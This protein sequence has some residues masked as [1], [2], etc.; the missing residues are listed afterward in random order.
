MQVEISEERKKKKNVIA[1]GVYSSNLVRHQI[2]YVA[3][4]I[5]VSVKVARFVFVNTALRVQ[6][7]GMIRKVVLVC[8]SREP[9]TKV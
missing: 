8:C 7:S 1:R 5:L 9:T 2:S 4:P 3:V 6:S